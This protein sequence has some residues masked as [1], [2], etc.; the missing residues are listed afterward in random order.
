[1]LTGLFYL[2]EGVCS[3]VREG[4]YALNADAIEGS[5]LASLVY[6]NERGSRSLMSTPARFL[7]SQFHLYIWE[8]VS[9]VI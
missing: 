7:I 3:K 9:P 4:R 6:S 1:M 5:T 2:V 8:R